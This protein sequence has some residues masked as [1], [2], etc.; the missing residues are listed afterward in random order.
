VNKLISS[1]FLKLLSTRSVYLLVAG[2]A[3][4]SVMTVLDVGSQ[5]SFAKPF[6]EQTFVFFTALLSRALILVLGIRLVTDEFRHGTVVPTILAAPQRTRVL[7]AKVAVATIGGVALAGA[8]WLAMTGA[9]LVIATVENASPSLGVDALRILGGMLAA[10]AIWGVL[11]VFVGAV[12][13][14][15]LAATVG[16]LVWLMA[17][18][19][20]GRSLLGDLGGYLPGQTALALV[21]MPEQ[22]DMAT[23]AAV[24]GVYL[25]G[26]AL[27]AALSMNRD[28]T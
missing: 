21:L 27:L 9:F 22:A 23:I 2:V 4:L 11:G 5:D 20:I 16:G 24:L 28:V 26:F 7:A 13:R 3:G 14:H 15:Q 8:A 25:A 10:G 6:D 12:I 18:E 1:E 19:D 17:I